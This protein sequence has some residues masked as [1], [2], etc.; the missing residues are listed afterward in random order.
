MSVNPDIDESDSYVSERWYVSEPW[1][2]ES[3]M[4]GNHD[5]KGNY[6]SEP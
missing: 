6:V 5:M 3:D 2:E 4:S 1:Y